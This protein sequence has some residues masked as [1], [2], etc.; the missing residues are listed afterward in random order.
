MT[1][2]RDVTAGALGGAL[3]V[4]LLA[5]GEPPA[6]TEPAAHAYASPA[7]ADAQCPSGPRTGAAGKSG[8][9]EL[10]PGT[11]VGVRAPTNYRADVAHPLLVVFAA[12]THDPQASE[13]FTRLTTAATRR[14]FVV[15]YV[16]SRRLTA[17]SIAR[18]TRVPAAV[19]ARWCIDPRRMVALGHSD[20]ATL[21]VASVLLPDSAF[22]PA[23]IVASAAGFR[24]DDL[25]DMACPAAIPAMFVQLR[26]D[27]LFPDYV[28][29]LAAWWAACDGC[30]AGVP[31]AAP[32]CSNYAG[33]RSGQ[34]LT[35]CE[36]DG[37]HSRWPG[38]NER[39]LDFL[40]GVNAPVPR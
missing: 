17:R 37:A 21:S 11:R 3:L 24:R 34:P 10:V 14:G 28:R 4:L 20:G 7:R 12:A 6:G 31:A 5:C 1:T 23:A 8:D 30:R 36:A 29:E 9:L 33:C 32:G 2:L 22:R 15:A 35:L 26:D 16:G 13:R 18:L 40:L 19:A 38:S 25:A 27:Q 39:M